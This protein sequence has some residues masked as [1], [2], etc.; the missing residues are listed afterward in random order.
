MLNI[1]LK[2]FIPG[3]NSHEDINGVHLRQHHHYLEVHQV[4][5]LQAVYIRSRVISVIMMWLSPLLKGLIDNE[6]TIPIQST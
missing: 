2:E 1:V 6:L 3:G 4:L 5:P